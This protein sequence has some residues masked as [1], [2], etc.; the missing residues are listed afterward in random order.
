MWEA[1]RGIL[2]MDNVCR[3]GLVDFYD[4]FLLFVFVMVPFFWMRDDVDEKIYDDVMLSSCNDDWCFFGFLE[5]K[6]GRVCFQDEFID[7]SGHVI[8]E[9]PSYDLAR[10][11]CDQPTPCAL[12][13]IPVQQASGN[14]G[15]SSSYSSTV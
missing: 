4:M 13:P 6:Q 9:C 12:S 14:Q 2:V 8:P 10:A 15:Y 7:P 1:G 5:G 3:V 11:L